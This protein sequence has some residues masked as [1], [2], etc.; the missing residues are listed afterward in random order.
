MSYRSIAILRGH[1][2]ERTA[3]IAEQC[4]AIGMDL[5]EVPVQGALGWDAL[6]AVANCANGRAFGAGTVLSPEGVTRAV[7]LGASVIISPGIDAEVVRATQDRGA[8]PLPGV[9]T[10][11]D[12]S[13]AAKLG[14]TVGKL[15]PADVV[16]T[17]WIKALKGPFPSMA[18]VAVGG[19]NATN[20]ASWIAAG[21]SGVAF[22]SSITEL[23][24][25]SNAENRI[26]DLHE[27]IASRTSNTTYEG[28]GP[29]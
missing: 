21:A 13:L 1:S 27:Q 22:G 16:G 8:L 18:V 11:T 25:L 19:V 26:R 14:L 5:V 12:L 4:W 10:P 15:F 28:A 2:A 23:L 29:A 24:G 9:M 3:D 7:G 20:A 6:E 17:S